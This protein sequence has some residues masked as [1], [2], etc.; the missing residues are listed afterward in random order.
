[1]KE[2]GIIDVFMSLYRVSSSTIRIGVIY[3][4]HSIDTRIHK[5]VLAPIEAYHS[6]K[7]SICIEH[8]C[9]WIIHYITYTTI[10]TRAYVIRDTYLHDNHFYHHVSMVFVYLCSHF[11]KVLYIRRNVCYFASCC[12]CCTRSYRVYLYCCNVSYFNV[13]HFS[14]TNFQVIYSIT[15]RTSRTI[16]IIVI[17]HLVWY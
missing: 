2:K 1:M 6:Q 11:K 10:N 4:R 9:F 17:Y 5:R 12:C 3:E 13:S 8:I 15:L 16:Y 14:F 7:R